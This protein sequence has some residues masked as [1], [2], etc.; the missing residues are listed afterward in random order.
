MKVSVIIPCY[1]VDPDFFKE[2]LLS[3]KA[4]SFNDFELIVIDDGSDEEYSIIIKE[5]LKSIIPCGKYYYQKNQGVSAARNNAVKYSS[6]DYICFMDSDDVI[7]P[8][9]LEEALKIVKKTNAGFLIGGNCILSNS[10]PVKEKNI[11][12]SCLSV[13]QKQCFKANMIGCI[14]NFGNQGGYFGRGPMTRLIRREY[15]LNTPF[16]TNLK[17]GEDIIWNIELLEKVENVV[18]AE[19]IW[20]LYRVNYASVTNKPNKDAIIISENELNAIFKHINAED[21]ATY[22]SYCERILQ[23]IQRVYKTYICNKQLCISPQH[24]KSA[25]KRINSKP[26]WNEI[27][28]IRAFRALSFKSKIKNA[29]IISGLYK[30]YII[31]SKSN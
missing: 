1:N 2:C 17:I 13:S 19:R 5:C 28:S 16:K 22:S 4:Q 12:Y 11:R 18:I 31:W 30:Y 7:L 8:Y 25:I 15:A 14:K 10:I 26:P 23:D 29:L 9:F 27:R 20:Y 6:G 24:K 3:V 21:K